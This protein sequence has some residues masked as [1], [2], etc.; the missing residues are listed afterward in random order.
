MLA[1][2]SELFVYL[3]HAMTCD[4]VNF[5]KLVNNLTIGNFQHMYSTKLLS[6]RFILTNYDVLELIPLINKAGGMQLTL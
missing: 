5:C 1:V 6:F 2:L 3:S 4:Q